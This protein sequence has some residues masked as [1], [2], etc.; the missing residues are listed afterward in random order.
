VTFHGRLDRAS[1][2]AL[3]TEVMAVVV[4]SRWNEN[5]PMVVLEAMSCG[6]PVIASRIGGIPELIEDGTDGHLVPPNDP[7]YLAGVLRD[8]L[9]DP[10]R[11]EGMGSAARAK[12]ADAFSPGKHLD[13]LVQAYHDAA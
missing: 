5:Q 3:M 7:R 11:A 13:H 2:A 1:A 12:V 8:L 4:P 10:D 6:R 9:A